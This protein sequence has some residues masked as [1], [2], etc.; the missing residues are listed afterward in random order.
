MIKKKEIDG[1]TAFDWG[2]TS[3]DYAKYRDIYPCSFYQKILDSGLCQ[4]G[5]KALD[6]GTG[7]GVLPRNLYHSGASFTATDI[8][9]NQ[10]AQ[11]K[12]LAEESGMDI[13]FLCCSTE[14]M[15]FPDNSFDTITAC[16]CFF[17]FDHDILAPKAFQILKTGGKLAAFYMAWLPNEDKIAEK[18]E[19][20][21][22]KYNPL[23]SGCG[24]T[25]HPLAIPDIYSRYFELEHNE[26]FDLA[27][28]FTKSGWNGRIKACRGIGA[29]LPEEEIKAF[30]QEHTALL[31]Q[32]APEEF[33][34][35]HYA[36]FLILK[37]KK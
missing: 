10:I 16:Q 12:R 18:S 17:Y 15:D 37:V 26:V 23:W 4:P 27:V 22:L 34:V 2:R 13:D 31:D 1:G 25:R 36:A 24:E 6:I 8:S 3:L 11:A 20:L 28:P 19:A 21:I 9:Q 30:E 35:L 32:I 7:S 5:Q 29:S 14:H 33:T